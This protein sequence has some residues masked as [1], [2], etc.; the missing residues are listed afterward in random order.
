MPFSSKQ[1]SHLDVVFQTTQKQVK[2]NKSTS[3]T[4]LLLF[5]FPYAAADKMMVRAPD[6]LPMF[7]ILVKDL[8]QESSNRNSNVLTK[9]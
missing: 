4:V 5:R 3:M 1:A 9:K 8:L 7:V 2:G 6:I